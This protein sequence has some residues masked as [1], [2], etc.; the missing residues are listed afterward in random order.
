MKATSSIDNSPRHRMPGVGQALS[1]V[2]DAFKRKSSGSEARKAEPAGPGL[3]CLHGR[4]SRTRLRATPARPRDS[5]SAG[6]AGQVRRMHATATAYRRGTS[7]RGSPTR[8][9]PPARSRAARSAAEWRRQRADLHDADQPSAQGRRQRAAAST[10][11]THPRQTKMYRSR[12][13]ATTHGPPSRTA[14]RGSPAPGSG[15]RRSPCRTARRT[16][17]PS[18]CGAPPSRRRRRAATTPMAMTR[19]RPRHGRR[20]GPGGEACERRD[21]QRRARV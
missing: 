2:S 4:L 13:D 16:R 3:A 7:S 19:D 6:R 21:Q 15:R 17:W 18:P 10:A 11:S 5:I 12:P 14:T 8:G 9:P 20:R 1:K